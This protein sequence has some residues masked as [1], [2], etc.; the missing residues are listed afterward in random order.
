ME[1][2]LKTSIRFPELQIEKA[3]IANNPVIQLAEKTQL[4]DVEVFEYIPNCYLL[5]DMLGRKIYLRMPGARAEIDDADY[6]LRAKN[7]NAIGDLNKDTI[8]KWDLHHRSKSPTIPSEITNAWDDTFLYKEE[9]PDTD[10]KGLRKPQAGALHSIASHWSTTHSPATIVM[11]TGTGKTEVMLSTLVS[12]GCNRVLVIIPSTPLKEQT[13]KKFVS[14]GCLSEIG[15]LPDSVVW[16][17]IAQINHSTHDTTTARQLAEASN[18]LIATP[19]V[20]NKFSE[21]ALTELVSHCSHLFID[22]AHHTPAKTWTKVRDLFKDKKI[23]Q[24]T[25]TPFRNDGKRIE[26]EIIYDYPLGMAQDN[27]YF[28]EI[29]LIR[30]NE[31]E[32][33]KSDETI[34]TEAVGLLKKDV[35]EDNL[36]HLLMVRAK[37][38]ERAR[39]LLPIYQRIGGAFNPLVVNYD[40]SKKER[41]DALTKLDTRQS[42]IVICVNMLGEGFDMPNLKIAA[43]HDIHKSLAITL[44][45]VGRFTRISN[46]NIGNATVVVNT[47]DPKVNKTLEALYSENPNW[48]KLLRES[49]ESSIERE[50]KIQEVILNFKGGLFEQISLWNLRPSLSTLIYKTKC[51]DWDTGA[52]LEG[53]PKNIDYWHAINDTEK[54]IVVVINQQEEVKWGRYKDIVNQSFDLCVA[55]WNQEKQFL[56]IQSSNYD[57][58]NCNALAEK[59]CGTDTTLHNGH[60]LFNIFTDVNLP[61][62]KNLGA[63]R[64]GTI[65]YTM[66]FGP[67]VIVGLSS[68]DKAESVPNNIF[69][70]GYEDGSRV[71]YGCS[72]KSGKVWSRGGGVI[73]DW[74]EWCDHVQKKIPDTETEE[75]AIIKDFLRPTPLNGRHQSVAIEAEWGEG[76]AQMNEKSASVFFDTDEYK[77]YDVDIHVVKHSVDGPIHIELSSD[78]KKSEYK[79][80]HEQVIDA[81]TGNYKCEYVSG[82]RIQIRKYSGNKVPFIDHI[83]SDPI[84][85]RYSD[86]S[87]SYGNYHVVTPAPGALYDRNNLQAVQWNIN[88]RNE[89]QGKDV[90]TDTIQYAMIQLLLDEYDVVFNDD[91][92]GEAADIV[93]LKK[94]GDDTYTLHLVH[95]KYSNT[96][97]PGADIS[98]LYEVCGQAQKSIKWKHGGLDALIEHI[99]QRE[100]SWQKDNH[101]RFI[102]GDFSELA[103]LK[104]FSRFAKQ[105]FK[106]SVVQP[107]L[108]KQKASDDII[109][110]IGC[111]ENYLVKTS[112]AELE[113]I[114]SE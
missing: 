30:V 16:P 35:E 54:I 106:V 34:A 26:G 59:L 1:A 41:D 18:V 46:S 57:A 97:T 11:P 32:E 17:R 98:N 108:S 15:V 19:M 78:D 99:K 6:I 37:N 92:S 73:L 31:I 23:L 7:L 33:E 51:E 38:I 89:S 5:I 110:L 91:G 83:K 3:R 49:S 94:D 61:M 4:V 68:I 40:F 44:Q 82:S 53:L 104:R 90:N 71:T 22:E 109:Q 24:F 113:I 69:G 76:L 60:R 58:F 114:C 95:C 84:I 29:N 42:R 56:Y 62:V 101:T 25:A 88:I 70:W 66:Y 107:G 87:F 13:Y 43:V 63:S 9:A 102:K 67:E 81:E 2:L 14:L 86:G 100:Q 74:K 80:V 10:K 105:K 8:L 111:T 77:L 47:A 39:A 21:E 27:G 55:Y 112:D 12:Q 72:A 75:I 36:D 45:F 93:C 96:D 85:I 48:N 64:T 50:K 28:K 79:L 65:S 103:S 20:L 52:F